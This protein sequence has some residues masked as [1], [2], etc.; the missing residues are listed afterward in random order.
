MDLVDVCI[1]IWNARGLNSPVRRLAVSQTISPARAA[2]VCLQETKMAVISDRVVR[3]CLGPAFDGFYYL[4]A[5]GT[6]GYPPSMAVHFGD[7][8]Q[9]SH[10]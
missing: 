8:V 9:P 6:R 4:P 5:V 3:E 2:V 1:A 10:D 7:G